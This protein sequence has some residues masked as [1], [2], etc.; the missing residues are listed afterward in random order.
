M[1]YDVLPFSIVG[2]KKAV[3]VLMAHASDLYSLSELIKKSLIVG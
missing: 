2:E 3:G 1:T